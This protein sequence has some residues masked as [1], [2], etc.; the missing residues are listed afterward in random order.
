MADITLSADDIA[1]V[2]QRRLAGFTPTLEQNTVGRIIEVARNHYMVPIVMQW[3]VGDLS[4]LLPAGPTAGV[5]K[6][7]AA[8]KPNG[9]GSGD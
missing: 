8:D 3:T 9:P 5:V 7:P 1:S 2:L 4:N 6:L